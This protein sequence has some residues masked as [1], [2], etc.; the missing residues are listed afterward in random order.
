[1]LKGIVA[2]TR[3]VRAPGLP[4]R[5]VARWF[6]AVCLAASVLPVTLP[7]A[8]AQGIG[9]SPAAAETPLGRLLAQA[10]RLLQAGQAADAFALLDAQATLYGGSVDFDLLLGIAALDSG[11]PEQAVLALERVLARD[12]DNL[13]A[14]AEI[15]RAYLQMREL[16]SA[17]REFETVSRANLP[18]AVRDT[19]QRFLDTVQRLEQ[20][21]RPQWLFT[22]DATV[23]WDSNVNF[24]SSFGEWVLGDGQALVPLPVA[25]PRSSSVFAL[26]AGATYIVPINGQLDWTTGLQ[27]AQR[28]YPSQH[29][30]D[31][32]SAEL[33]TGLSWATG[34]H[35]ISMSLQYQHLRLDNEPFR[36]AAGVIG[37]W[38]YDAAARTQVGAYLQYFDLSFPE[39]AV[40][41][42]S[43]TSAGATLAHGFGGPW[44]AVLAAS[45]YGG[46]DTAYSGLPQLSFEFVGLR[47]ALTVPLSG[48][49]RGIGGWSFERRGFDGPEPLFGVT[50]VDHQNDLSLAFERDLTRQWTISPVLQYTR[51]QS[52]IAPNDFKRT[53]AYLFA[54]Y[55][56]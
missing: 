54:R 41:D 3:R 46:A 51:N 10:R 1:M 16:P 33:S 11:R 44:D 15:G 22:V 7:G 12:P 21:G 23:G 13:Q 20:S 2:V 4:H 43:R 31:M 30:M 8:A 5:C 53:Q 42:A 37:Q 19:V 25:R 17:R 40:R 18:P 26:G 29:N 14:R 56:F 39:Q 35:R 32:G 47:T 50:R 9:A 49:W 34:A 48:G 45:V 38:Q 36:N 24:G 55:R 6:A 28:I 27:I 52:T